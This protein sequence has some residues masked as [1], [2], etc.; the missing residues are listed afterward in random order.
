MNGLPALL[1]YEL[2]AQTIE[3]LPA[4]ETLL[5]IN[6]INVI[7]VNISL[8]VN[9]ASYNASA[10]AVAAQQLSAWQH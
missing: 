3:L 9:A 1:D 10:T 8:A 4:R 5:T 2:A 6:V 7:G